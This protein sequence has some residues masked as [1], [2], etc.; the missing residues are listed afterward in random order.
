MAIHDRDEI[1]YMPYDSIVEYEHSDYLVTAR[2]NFSN[3][4]LSYLLYEMKCKE[5]V[6]YLW[7]DK[8]EHKMAVLEKK[9]ESDIDKATF[10][11]LFSDNFQVQ[12]EKKDGAPQ[13]FSTRLELHRTASENELILIDKR[14]GS[15]NFFK[16]SYVPLSNLNIFPYGE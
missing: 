2:S 12:I 8:Q 5:D 7:Y 13:I 6:K 10:K 11:Q 9:S 14:A 16:G 1:I 4:V 15:C 3:P